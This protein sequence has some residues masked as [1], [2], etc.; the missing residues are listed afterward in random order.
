MVIKHLIN[1]IGPTDPVTKILDDLK[2]LWLF[3]Q[4]ARW[5]VWPRRS[6]DFAVFFAGIELNTSVSD[7]L[8]L[9]GNVSE[10]RSAV[11]LHLMNQKHLGYDIAQWL[12]DS[13]D[14]LG[15]EHLPFRSVISSTMAKHDTMYHFI[16]TIFY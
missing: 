14:F 13:L 4:E 12:W 16:V 5:G 10:Y 2:P 15:Y 7:A 8:D 9:T 1:D 11:D 3:P 6:N